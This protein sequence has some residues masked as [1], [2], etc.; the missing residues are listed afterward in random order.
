MR[1][2]GVHEVMDGNRRGDGDQE[3]NSS[4]QKLFCLINVS[5]LSHQLRVPEQIL[6]LLTRSMF[7]HKAD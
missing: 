5:V 4:S 1:G 6:A 2:S 3:A 7:V